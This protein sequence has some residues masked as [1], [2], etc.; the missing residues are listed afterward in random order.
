MRISVLGP[1]SISR[2]GALV[3][4]GELRRQRVRELLCFLVVRRRARREDIA[5]ELW[6][7]LDDRGHNLRVTL[8]YLQRVLQPDRATSDP[9][10]FLRSNGPWLSL[11]GLSHLDV[12]TWTLDVLLDDAQRAERSGTPAA[13]LEFYRAALPLWSGEPFGDVPYADWA[14]SEGARL[15]ARYTAAAVRAGELLLAAGMPAEARA[16]AQHA[17]EADRTAESAYQ[18]LARSHLAENDLVGARHAVD[19]CRTALA[20]LDL[21]PGIATIALLG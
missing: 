14:D 9:P 1:L 18:L 21:R 15:R 8:N 19:D 3:N 2:D 7:D 6:P 17:I 11:E 10:Y 12:D 20:E 16:A 13:A 4:Q 5:E